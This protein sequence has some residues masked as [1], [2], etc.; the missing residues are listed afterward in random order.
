M[1]A[2][3]KF[4]EIFLHILCLPF[5]IIFHVFITSVFHSVLYPTVILLCTFASFS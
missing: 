3:I 5:K 2:Q 4:N 1:T